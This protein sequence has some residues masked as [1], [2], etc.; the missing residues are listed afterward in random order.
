MVLDLPGEDKRALEA[1]Q[2]EVRAVKAAVA[3]AG[4]GASLDAA[5]G[6]GEM[7][8]TI[9]DLYCRTATLKVGRLLLSRQAVC[10]FVSFLVY[11]I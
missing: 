1:M 2:R 10:T 3:S 11:R 9:L 7:R 5:G 8:R 6:G 4:E